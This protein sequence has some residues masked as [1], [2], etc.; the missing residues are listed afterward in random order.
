MMMMMMVCVHVYE[1]VNAA[2]GT[3]LTTIGFCLFSYSSRKGK[4]ALFDEPR[5]ATM[6]WNVASSHWHMM[7]LRR[8]R[9]S[10][11]K[12][13]MFVDGIYR[14]RVEWIVRLLSLYFC[15]SASNRSALMCTENPVARLWWWWRFLATL[16]NKSHT[17][18][19][20]MQCTAMNTYKSEN[21]PMHT[22]ASQPDADRN[23]TC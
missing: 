21:N 5:R 22:N 10:V 17:I 1:S 2:R 4:K 14:L 9:P 18:H 11:N 7:Q 19:Q 16:I 20:R 23:D 8:E 13:R 12:N 15:V 6:S 3:S